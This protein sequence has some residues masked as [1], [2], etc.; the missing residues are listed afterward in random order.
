MSY[1]H[2]RFPEGKPKAVTF[3]YDDGVAQDIRLAALADRYGVK[4][5]FNINSAF[6]AEAPGGDKLTYA[7]IKSILAQGHEA[8]IHG[9]YHLAP[10][11]SRTLVGLRDALNCRLQLERNLG[12]IIR[13]MAY[14]N[15]GVTRFTG[16]SDYGTVRRY[17]QDIGVV[18]ARSLGSDNNR[19]LLPEDWYCWI[20]TA[21]H[22]NPKALDWAK[23]FA[24]L[25]VNEA[26]VDNR[27]ARLFYLWGHSYEFD[28][29]G[30]WDRIEALCDILGGKDDTWYATNIDICDYVSAFRALVF[31][32]DGSL[33]YNP[34]VKELWFETEQGL[35]RVR[36]GE[37]AAVAG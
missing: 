2:M 28:R 18:Y 6:V 10:G 32:A 12:G 21:H 8:A 20:P 24:D 26:Y 37:T 29:N 13:G 15:S 9:E 23:E 16:G 5:T 7:Q 19:F 14:P 17:L 25:R 31:S 11:S 33:V 1:L 34:T 4:C 30:N 35:C 3:S 27:Y 36:P 22:E